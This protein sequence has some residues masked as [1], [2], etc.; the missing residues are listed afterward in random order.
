MPEV[1]NVPLP[2]LGAIRVFEAV[3]RRMSFTRAA[4]ELG[5]TQ[6]AASYQIKALEERL[7]TPVFRRLGREIQLTRAGE[8]LALAATEAMG[9]LRNAVAEVAGA[10]DGVLAV[11][12]LHT[13]A[14]TWLV[15]RLGSFQLAN[16]GL[17]VRLDTSVRII[18]LVHE[19]FD[20]GLRAGM[21]DWPGLE[22]TFL[23]PGVFT[24]LCTPQIAAELGGL[25]D[26]RQLLDAPLIGDRSEW[27]AW[28]AAAGLDYPEGSGR[29]TMAYEVQQ[30]DV[31]AAAAGQGVAM[32][33]PIFF[34]AD[35]AAGRLVQ[36]F[37]INVAGEG[38]YWLVHAQSRRRSP[39]ITA[40]C[41][42][43]LKAV[44][45]DPSVQRV[46]AAA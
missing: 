25:T 34:A 37:D 33:S 28:L 29:P 27:E 8:R 6:A 38:G 36:P 45:D 14:V 19:D 15:P 2:S 4:E 40:F 24:P 16:P 31:A 32:G 12:C 43:L 18:D 13:F 20:I 21:G 5:M 7:G 46:L 23:F 41:E 22:A 10:G 44:A 39:K 35:I 11:T 3:A 30:Y 42:W 9:L 17:A 1:P 26:P